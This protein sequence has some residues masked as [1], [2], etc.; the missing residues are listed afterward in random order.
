MLLSPA[1]AA[2]A[3]AGDVGRIEVGCENLG[4]RICRCDEIRGEALAAAEITVGEGLSLQPWRG[5]TFGEGGE[6][7]DR[8]RLDSAKVVHIRRVGDIA[9]APFRH[10]HSSAR[11]TG[12]AARRARATIARAMFGA[13]IP[14]ERVFSKR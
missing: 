8:R 13:I 10:R 7:Q 2:S 4:C 6:A 12:T 1:A 9:G 5:N 14:S 3:R 11:M